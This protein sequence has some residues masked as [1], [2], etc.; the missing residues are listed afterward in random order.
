MNQI[1]GEAGHERQAPDPRVATVEQ[2]VDGDTL[3][4]RFVSGEERRLRYIGIDTPE[5]GEP[6]FDEATAANAALVPRGSEIRLVFDRDRTDRF[7][8]L[9]AY[10]HRK[11]DDLFVNLEM[12]RDGYAQ[13][14][15]VEPNTRFKRMFEDA[16]RVPSFARCG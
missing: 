3:R 15:T 13:P 11:R 7:G 16:Q 4:V 1:V 5:R 6:C 8:R 14:L 10:V 12:V 9:L 2:V